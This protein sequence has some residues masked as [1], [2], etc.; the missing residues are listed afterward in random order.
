MC[1]CV[2]VCVC[3]HKTADLTSNMVNN[4]QLEPWNFRNTSFAGIILVN[5]DRTEIKETS[6]SESCQL[7]VHKS[8]EITQ[9][10]DDFFP[11]LTSSPSL[12]SNRC[13]KFLSL[14]RE[15]W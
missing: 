13:M 7:S 11:S 4:T 2:C 12:G 5:F 8:T 6:L 3:V 14:L 9:L 10:P 15:A 1:V